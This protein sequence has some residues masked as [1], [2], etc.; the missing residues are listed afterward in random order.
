MDTHRSPVVHRLYSPNRRLSVTV[1]LDRAGYLGYRV[2]RDRMMLIA[3]SPLGLRLR[4][5]PDAIGN[6]EI[7]AVDYSTTDERIPIVAGKSRYARD[8]HNQLALKL[9]DREG[10]ACLDVIFRASDDG[11]AFRYRL[12]RRPDGSPIELENELTGFY[13]PDDCICWAMNLPNFATSH[14]G[15]F[16]RT[17]AAAI[18]PGDMIDPPLLCRTATAAFA[19]AEADLDNYA[20]AYFCSRSD[21]G[22]GVQVALSPLPGDPTLAV[23]LPADHELQSPWRVIMIADHPGQLIEATLIH[24]LNPPSIIAD[25]S[26]IRPGKC[27]WDWWCG[28]VVSGVAQPGMNDATIRRFIDFAAET[29]LEYMMIDAGWYVSGPDGENDPRSDITRSIPEIDLPGLVDYASRRNVGLFVW[30]AW[31]P[32]ADQMDQALPLYQR[33]G[34]KGVKVDFMDRND[35]EMVAFYHRLLA[36]AAQHQLM[37]DLH[38]AYPPTGLARTYPNLLTQE[39]VMGAEYNKWSSRVTATHNV[40]LPYTR[41]LLGAMDYTPGGFRHASPGRFE[42]RNTLPL[43]QTTRSQALAMYVVYDSPLVSLADTP[44]AYVGEPGL[45]FLRIVP[46]TWDE[47]RFLLGEVGEFI[48]LARRSG[49][50][51]FVGAMTNEAARR[52]LV[53]LSFVQSGRFVATI[54]DDGRPAMRSV[55]RD[56]VLELPL[57]CGGGAAIVLRPAYMQPV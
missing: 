15:E 10:C 4:G 32:M 49:D 51:W 29:G 43:V 38:G 30:I 2:E 11:V 57:A 22:V 16:R 42:A 25:T 53:P 28:S 36:K 35:Q 52:L 6:L 40:T 39:G 54:Y 55:D 46:T 17:R 31:R 21:G 45:D 7:A 1:E 14:E 20:G 41:M 12:P 19:I 34:L 13:F 8:H 26:W 48:V 3:H 9:T 23:R 50:Q 47:T 18:R 56:T 5:A 27:A 33:L 37:V 44:D 24:V